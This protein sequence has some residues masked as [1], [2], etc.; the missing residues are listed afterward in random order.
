MSVIEIALIAAAR[1][2]ASAVVPAAEKLTVV[3]AE[4]ARLPLI[5][6]L[7]VN[8]LDPAAN[9]LAVIAADSTTVAPVVSRLQ[10]RKLNS[11]KVV[12]CTSGNISVPSA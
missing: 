4:S 2:S 9:V 3:A 5:L 12:S 11:L 8:V 1:V 10:T 6:C 7:I